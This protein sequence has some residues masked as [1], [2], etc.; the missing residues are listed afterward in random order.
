MAHVFTHKKKW[1]GYLGSNQGMTESKSVALPL[2]YSPTKM[3]EG[4][5]FELPN[6]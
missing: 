2:G 4:G 1:L 5:R 6:P 3:V